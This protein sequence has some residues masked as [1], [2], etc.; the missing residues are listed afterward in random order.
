[1]CHN[2]QSKD[3]KRRGKKEK[4]TERRFDEEEVVDKLRTLR[5]KLED[6]KGKRGQERVI[7]MYWG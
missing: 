5:K 3:K 2:L 7:T 4:G 1:M 6:R